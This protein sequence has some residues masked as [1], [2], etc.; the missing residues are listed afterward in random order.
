MK[1][2]IGLLFLVSAPLYA[3]TTIGGDVCSTLSLN[4]TYM[5]TLTG[6]QINAS[7][8][9]TNI[10]QANGSVT[11]DG[12]SKLTMTLTAD[13]LKGVGTAT[14]Y[15]GTYTVQ[16]NC[17]GT[18]SITTGDTATYNLLIYNQGNDFLL[19][20]TDAAYNLTGS[21][22]IQSTNACAVGKLSGAYSMN[23][24]GFSMANGAVSGVG[25]GTGLI[26]FD[27]KSA[28][29]A[30]F[31]LSTVGA[32]SSSL[33]MTGSYSLGSNCL[34]TASLTDSKGNAY[35]M[36][37]VATGVSATA[38]TGFSVTLGQS[39]KLTLLGAG[40]GVLP[41]GSCA[42]GDVIGPYALVLT[43][44]TVSSSGVFTGSFQANGIATFDGLGKVTFTGTD[45]TNLATGKA[46]NYSG[47][48]AI[49]SNCTGTLTITT[50]NQG[51]SNLALSMVEW[52]SGN[53]FNLAGSDAT[54]NYTGSG[55]PQPGLCATASISGDYAYTSSGFT[56]AGSALNGTG[57]E[58]GLLHFDGQGNVTAGYNSNAGGSQVSY[59]A[60]GT[61][62]VAPNCTG[63]ATWTDNTGK[64]TAVNLTVTNVNNTA[65]SLLEASSTFIRNGT[66]HSTFLNPDEYIANVA[67]YVTDST[68]PGSVFVLF[69]QNL[70][71]R[72][73]SAAVVP[74]PNTLSNTSVTVNGEPAPLF[75][76]D[77]GQIDAQM[78][79]DI[80]GNTIAAVV[81]K[82][83]SVVS[84]A[85]GVYVPATGTPG[86]SVYGNNRA[87]VVNQNGSINSGTDTANVGDTVVAYFTGGGPVN[88]A[89]KLTTG[90][91]SPAG[92]SPVTG[93]STI[94]VN[95]VNAKISYIGL[96]PGSVGLYQANFVVPNVPKGTYPVIITIAGTP[97][98]NPVMTVAN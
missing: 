60:T 31:N 8:S 71:A 39:G 65:F 34:G 4:G 7:G 38:V 55:S 9:Y 45:N 91:A 57:D 75:Y 36:A 97:S 59:T 76:V 23:A 41:A 80:P 79:W 40:H 62:S 26:Q 43:G 70:A 15:A 3:Q 86:L 5:M 51:V 42:T 2:S 98:N 49:G 90:A 94:T 44:R 68:P 32:S 19:A 89:G 81:V 82:N 28:V 73:V 69:G 56:T 58:A 29:T 88:A 24:T 47:T 1:L 30:N 17:A 37:L 33:A 63:S 13:T 95:G 25:D 93:Q 54:Y 14:S 92:L 83:G 72:T 52:G 67:S 46:L 61:Y 96:T 66:A 85:A 18:V 78:P 64:A 22:S 12:Q 35:T 16:A 21:G 84:N 53:D 10:L 11:F 74:L 50:E 87:V 48:Y 77:S 20:G 27:G 6:R